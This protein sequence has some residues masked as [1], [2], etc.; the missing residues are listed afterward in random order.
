MNYLLLNPINWT[1]VLT[2]L[3]I[4]GALSI[5]FAILIL[6][7]S[8]VCAVT[9]DE[10]V[11]AV[12]ENLAGANC[13]GCGYAGCEGFAKALC[14]GNAEISSCGPTSNEAKAKIAEI[15]GIP[16]EASEEKFA[17]I[18]CAGGLNAMNKFNYVGNKTCSA[19]IVYQ[20]GAKV[21]PD[22]CLGLGSCVEVCPYDA[23]SIKDGVSV[24]DKVLCEACG[25]CVKTCS[26][27]L[28]DFIPKTAKV[29]VACSTKCR[30]KDVMTAC[31]VG[32]I[33]CGLCVKNCPEQAITLVDNLPVIDYT[34]CTGCKTCVTKCPR[35]S[36]KEL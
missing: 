3:L 2:V 29:F 6:I 31:K 30:G 8:K 9:E 18:H 23:I 22:G 35:K 26:K 7:V 17:I 20:G 15:L 14:Q 5:I 25:L 11:N 13:G 27:H 32:C 28:I 24:V 19:Q 36:I 33:G 1:S 21:C 4:V 34:K 16:F 12:A 10:K